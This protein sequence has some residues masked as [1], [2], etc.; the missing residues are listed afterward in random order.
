MNSFFSLILISLISSGIASPLKY[1]NQEKLKNLIS[2][3]KIE[4]QNNLK[5]I[6][7]HEK[8]KIQINED[9]KL[10]RDRKD[11][12]LMKRKKD[13][14]QLIN[15]E[16][17]QL[18]KKNEKLHD[19]IDKEEKAL[20]SK[21]NA[22]DCTSNDQDH[23]FKDLLAHLGEIERQGQEQYFK[24]SPLR[25]TDDSVEV[26]TLSN[27]FFDEDNFNII[28]INLGY[29][30]YKPESA[31]KYTFRKDQDL[32][33]YTIIKDGVNFKPVAKSKTS[34]TGINSLRCVKLNQDPER[35]MHFKNALSRVSDYE[36][37]F[38]R[39]KS[40]FTKKH[41]LDS[42]DRLEDHLHE[43]QGK[44]AQEAAKRAIETERKRLRQL[45]RYDEYTQEFAIK[46]AKIKQSKQTDQ[47]IQEYLNKLKTEADSRFK[48]Y[49][50][51]KNTRLRKDLKSL[52]LAS[53]EK[54]RATRARLFDSLL[55]DL[56]LN[57]PLEKWLKAE[58]G[59]KP[60]LW[61]SKE[62]LAQITEKYEQQYGKNFGFF[63]KNDNHNRITSKIRKVLVEIDKLNQ[64]EEDYNRNRMPDFVLEEVNKVNGRLR[65]M[66]EI[67]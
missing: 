33:H 47:Q 11:S 25:N 13:E 37:N 17:N 59:F 46:Q 43:V 45:V 50:L 42:E 58:R 4:F 31:K 40:E 7:D 55:H 36:R 21:S 66:K 63:Y 29:D 54:S 23:Q 39:L 32:D 53:I 15:S 12:V 18:V 26:R 65:M 14:T 67:L 35:E 22:L 51:V 62:L 41:A 24:R 64:D 10:A 6:Q 57:L 44:E 30:Y 49:N 38:Q 60:N 5:S 3:Q 27:T 8:T 9:F 28:C 48:S 20:A 19:L 56:G 1:L 16:I 34:R 2:D 52:H 61:L